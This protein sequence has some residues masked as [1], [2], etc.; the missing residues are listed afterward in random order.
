MRNRR[1]Y[2][3]RGWIVGILLWGV[4]SA[5]CAE[6]MAQIEQ[7]PKPAPPPSTQPE[8][9]QGD[10]ALKQGNALN[11]EEALGKDVIHH[12]IRPG[13]TLSGIAMDYYDT[14]LTDV[15][16][17]VP[18][19]QFMTDE[20]SRPYGKE[21]VKKMGK[22]AD[23]IARLNQLPSSQLK[24][25]TT[26]TLPRILGLPF[27]KPK[28]APGKDQPST[29]PKAEAS[30]QK[31]TPAPT[32]EADFQNLM[33]GGRRH[34]QR[35]EYEAA[36]ASLF[37]AHG[38]KPRDPEVRNYLFRSY[39]AMGEAAFQEKAF[40]R[41]ANAFEKA[42]QYND[43]C[44]E[45]REKKAISEERYKDLHYKQGIRYFEDEQLVKAIEEWEQVRKIDPEYQN[46]QKNIEL[47]R[48]LL[49]RLGEMEEGS[50]EE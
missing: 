13:E 10:N 24:V 28:E 47:A 38:L 41:A 42:L 1:G 15:Y 33:A 35:G 37:Q 5:G 45:C 8:K 46:V 25:G 9:S 36:V 6:M 22:V 40:L 39:V 32:S 43:A 12:Q 14:Y 48:R 50:K 49:K 7:K 3:G 26:I 23:V 19:R 16:F 44:K 18:F 21:A 2:K 30:Q 34:F 31:E 17:H 20:V 4:L 11:M 29:K 27:Q